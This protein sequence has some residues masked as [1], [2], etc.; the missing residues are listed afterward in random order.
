MHTVKTYEPTFHWMPSLVLLMSSVA[1]LPAGAAT[2]QGKV[3]DPLGA[4]VPNAQ[5]T[6]LRKGSVVT[7][8]R[9]AADG[10]FVFS[11]VEAGRCRVAAEA[12]GFER[13]ESA[14]LLVRA[15]EIVRVDVRLQ[16]GP[17][18]QQVVVSDSGTGLPE[19]EVGSAVS[20]SDREQLD[21]LNKLDVLDV[22]RLTPGVQVV[23]T[24]QRGGTTSIFVRGGD[25]EFNKVLIDGIPANDIGGAFEFANLSTSG[26]DRVETLRGPN[27]VLY[28]SDSLASVINITT[29]H[30]TTPLPEFIL[31]ADGGNFGTHREEGSVSG[32]FRQFDYF[33]DFARFDTQNSL[34]NSSFHNGTYAGNFG[35]EPNAR[36][37]VRF[38]LRHTAV[39]LGDPNA[40]G[41]YGI[42]DNSFEREQDTY[43]GVTVRNQT[44][45]HWDNLLSLTDTHLRFYYDDPSPTGIPFNAPGIGV[46]YLG[47][48]VTICGANGFCA[49]GQAILDFGGTYPELSGS[50]TTIRSVYAQSDYVFDPSLGASFGFRYDKEDGFT[51][52]SGSRSSTDR[53][54]FHYFLEGHGSLRHRLFATAGVGFDDNAVF[55]FA[56]TPR[57]SVAYYIRQ[58][59]ADALF[60]D[61]KL[62]FNFGTGI[63]E[64]SIF[65]EG[66]SLFE[67][68]ETLPQGQDL[69][70]KFGISPIGAERSRSLDLGLDEGLWH[71]RARLGLTFFD[72]HFFDLIEFVDN[73]ALPQLGVPPEVASA[74]PFGATINSD[75]FR[76]RG[77]EAEFKAS[78]SRNLSL[79][80]EYTYLS[81][82][83]TKSFA[84]S[85]LSPAINPAFPGVPIGAFSPLVGSR[86]FLRAPHSGSL[87]IAYS[88]RRYGVNLT[89]YFV[90]KSDDSTFL[91]D[92]FF[93]NTML[94]PNRN[95]CAGYQLIDASGWFDARRGITLYASMGNILSEHY[96]A[97]FGYPALPFT[98]RTGIKITLGGDSWRRK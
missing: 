56:A 17:L 25:A 18:R 4:V 44:T 95:L 22:L 23:Q 46:N 37:S 26:V 57:V 78:L 35:W 66:S 28:G 49:T 76:S 1:A 7:T 92:A 11:T 41:F 84:S 52:S 13:A 62:R 31:F 24:G 20:V 55:G 48:P 59:S 87:L 83:V 12:K 73:T 29:R 42:P 40:L 70:R 91:S 15:G 68:L 60:G 36:T 89:G 90:S 93:G 16:V 98:F 71:E 72:N 21:A 9:A 80:A 94:L 30:G 8:T 33:S 74:L 50:R 34:P 81:A 2:I 19:S 14:P 65:D 3:T 96:D 79:R 77:A 39:G 27:S 6:L 54:N 63:E 38:T 5:V 32:L 51:E 64:P 86:P 47:L 82:V 97:A 43:L 45:A 58:P 75:S 53:N 67:V 69:I 85:A 10:T 88:R 61:T